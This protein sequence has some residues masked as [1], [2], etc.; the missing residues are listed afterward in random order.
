MHPVMLLPSHKIRSSTCQTIHYEASQ[1]TV[2]NY[3][4]S[5]LFICNTKVSR[6]IFL[7]A[8]P[9]KC[10]SHHCSLL[11]SLLPGSLPCSS[12][13]LGCSLPPRSLLPPLAS[14]LLSF[15]RSV[16]PLLRSTFSMEIPIFDP[17][18]GPTSLCAPP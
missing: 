2:Y 12:P 11:P 13:S 7:R 8:P 4:C 5:L 14:S 18:G 6:S 9:L 17:F 10:P 1:Y 15:P 3:T 16:H